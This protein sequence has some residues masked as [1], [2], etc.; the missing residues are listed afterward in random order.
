MQVDPD[1]KIRSKLVRWAKLL[2]VFVIIISALVLVG[3]QF[4]IELFKRLFP[5]LIAMNPLTAVAFI[6]SG[7]SFRLLFVNGDSA[8]KT[9]IAKILALLVVMIA[10]FKLFELV[11]GFHIGLDQVLYHT[12]LH[13]EQVLGFV[14]VMAPNTAFCFLLTGLGLVLFNYESANRKLPAHY[15][16]LVVAFLALLSV[17]GY[18]YRVEKFYSVLRF[19]PMALHTALC[20]LFMALALLF[21]KP[22]RGV[23]REFVRSHSGSILARKV[24]PAA[25]IIPIVLGWLRLYGDRHGWYP[26][27]MGTAILILTIIISFLVLI[28]YSAALLNRRDLERKIAEE[29]LAHFNLELERKVEERTADVLRHEIRF[30]ALIENNSDVILMTDADGKTIYQSPA[31][32]RVTGRT[33]EDQKDVPGLDF[34]HPDDLPKLK[35]IL[36]KVLTFPGKSF[37]FSHRLRHKEG[38]YIWIEGVIT[39]LLDDPAVAAIISN[40][41][42]VSDKKG[43][44]EQL[45]KSEKRFRAMIE[46]SVDVVS[47]ADAG[48]RVF[49]V[50]PSV[51]K[52]FG[53]TTDEYLCQ[54]PAHF[55]HPND[56][57]GLEA[58]VRDIMSKPGKSFYRQQRLLHKDGSWRWCEGVMTNMLHDPDIAALISNFRDI[59]ER[60]KAEEQQA[61]FVSI[62]DS[63]DDAI[64]S[65]AVDGTITSWNHGAENIFGYQAGEIIGKP[66][67]TLIPQELHSDERSMIEDIRSGKAVQHYE[68]Q[69]IRKDGTRICVSLAASPIK[70]S[71]GKIVGVSRILRDV[72]E[73]VL[74]REQIQQLNESLEQKVLERTAQLEAVNKEL[75]SFSYSVSHDLRAPL[76]GIDGYARIIEEDYFKLFDEEAK[77]LFAVIQYNAKKMGTLI[78]DLL[79]FSRLGRKDLNKMK[80]NMNELVE[81]AILELEKSV[82]HKARIKIGELGTA[83]VDYGLISQV[84]INLISNAIKY[85]SKNPEPQISI[86]VER[87]KNE[88]IYSVSD[89]GV[90]FDMKYAHKLF[91]VFQ[92]LHSEADFE[93]TGVGLA[94]V[95]RIINKHGG[96]V[97]AEAKPGEGATFYFSLPIENNENQ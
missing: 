5:N 79:S 50:T 37:S 13:K 87:G 64:V 14:N 70:D 42:D 6:F 77:R 1:I 48:G 90:G 59:S 27:E 51:E 34:V 83:E 95:Q 12:E 3:W 25:I 88:I 91:G 93:G 43:A 67:S 97:W 56:L 61:L 30:R 4:N 45:Q 68:T 44:E 21:I 40:Y 72:T 28:G 58:L 76:R 11:S 20:F 33:L 36:R 7:F 85:S 66:I 24:I 46:K 49:Y 39:N 57:P 84:M 23:I 29:K 53:F 35:E 15:I 54:P 26:T 92:R 78:D 96:R 19:I 9:L 10:A 82:K 75:E 80:V 47:L 52:V 94:I 31:A 65:T 8:A 63:S 89:N 18:M 69:R 55:I 81:G 74:A 60:K 38:H 22:E 41:R 32:F 71:T 73:R 86:N 16:A 17:V 2:P 62:V